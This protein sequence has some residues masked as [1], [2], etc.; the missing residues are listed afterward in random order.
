MFWKKTE[1][2]EQ[3]AAWYAVLKKSGF[4]DI[5][6]GDQL[7]QRAT[8]AYKQATRV[9]RHAKQEYFLL[10]SQYF[11]EKAPE[12]DDSIDFFV[13]HRFA[14]G[15]SN[16]EICDALEALG[17]PRHRKTVMFIRRKYENRWG[18]RKWSPEQLRSRKMPKAG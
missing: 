11:R 6:V 15:R 3:Q 4:K 7:K 18:I 12:F 9:E 8:N 13:M 10:L 16:R 1:F 14:L 2:K 5:E 17:H